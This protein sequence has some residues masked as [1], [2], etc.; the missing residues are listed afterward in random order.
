MFP[1]KRNGYPDRVSSEGQPLRDGGLIVAAIRPWPM[2]VC[3]ELLTR[4]FSRLRSS[5]ESAA[6][7]SSHLRRV[8]ARCIK[9]HQD[10]PQ[11]LHY[12]HHAIDGIVD[13]SPY[14][15]TVRGGRGMAPERSGSRGHF[16]LGFPCVL[17]DSIPRQLIYERIPHARLIEYDADSK[18]IARGSTHR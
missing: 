6:L 7:V 1:S 16:L 5:P 2:E 8:L 14:R 10:R 12:A 4:R 18:C 15:P 9:L 13:L 17:H 11:A 3:L